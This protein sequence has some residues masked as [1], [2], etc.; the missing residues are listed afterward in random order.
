MG[1]WGLA[2]INLSENV[3]LWIRSVEDGVVVMNEKSK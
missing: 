3:P 1:V 2:A